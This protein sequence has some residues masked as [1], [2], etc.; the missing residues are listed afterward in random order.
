MRITRSITIKILSWKKNWHDT[1]EDTW[2]FSFSLYSSQLVTCIHLVYDTYQ[3][4]NSCEVLVSAIV[5]HES[6]AKSTWYTSKINKLSILSLLA[7]GFRI[8]TWVFLDHYKFPWYGAFLY[9]WKIWVTN[10]FNNYA[11][12]NQDIYSLHDVQI[13]DLKLST[14]CKYDGF[15]SMRVIINNSHY[16]LYVVVL[17]LKWLFWDTFVFDLSNLKERKLI[18]SQ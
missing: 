14:S 3:H 16:A 5:K 11:F 8:K 9:T 18:N 7:I 10:I 1:E 15:N 4:R 13:K 12:M 2:V 17:Y 6:R